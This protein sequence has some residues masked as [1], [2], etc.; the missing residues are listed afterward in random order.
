MSEDRGKYHIKQKTMKTKKKPT[1]LSRISG[2]SKTIAK[3]S[4]KKLKAK[5]VIQAIDDKV[6]VMSS[7]ES[8]LRTVEDTSNDSLASF[9]QPLE[10]LITEINSA[11]EDGQEAEDSAREKAYGEYRIALRQLET[12]L[13]TDGTIE[14]K[15]AYKERA[16]KELKQ[17]RNAKII[18]YRAEFRD[19]LAKVKSD[20]RMR[21][22]IAQRDQIQHLSSKQILVK[23]GQALNIEP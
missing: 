9:F 3:S 22:T 5:K 2:I 7:L 13:I 8:A 23:L 4:T 15:E 14:D 19:S 11:V 10:D 17:R 6:S 16:I 20:Q 21:Q 1:T 18:T 12:R